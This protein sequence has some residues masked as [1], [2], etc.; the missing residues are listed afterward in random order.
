MYSDDAVAPAFGEMLSRL[1]R[2][3]SDTEPTV[4]YRMQSTAV[5]NRSH[6]NQG[7]AQSECGTEKGVLHDLEDTTPDVILGL[8]ALGEQ[9][10]L[11]HVRVNLVVAIDGRLNLSTGQSG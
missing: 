5:T 1:R 4:S 2:A 8:V 10:Y 6:S 9:T 3:V 7:T 11:R